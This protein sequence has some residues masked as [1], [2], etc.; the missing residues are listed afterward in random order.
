MHRI[1]SFAAATVLLCIAAAPEGVA[2][3]AG[4]TCHEFTV[5][6]NVDD[7]NGGPWLSGHTYVLKASVTVPSNTT[8]TIQ[9]GA[10][11][12]TG[13]SVQHGLNAWGTVKAIGTA[14]SPILFTS[15][16]DDTGGD[17]NG[18][19]GAT[20]PG[21]GD[22]PSVRLNAGSTNSEFDHCVV[23]FGGLGG[24]ASVD[25]D[26]DGLVL[27]NTTIEL[28]AG[29]GLRFNN[30]LVGAVED[31]VFDSCLRPISGVSVLSVATIKNCT[32][33]GNAQGDV[34]WADGTAAAAFSGNVTWEKAN[35]L[36][37]NGV[38]HLWAPITVPNGT[39]FRVKQ[40]VK[41]KFLTTLGYVNVFGT[42]I[43]EGTAGDP[44]VFT[45]ISDDAIGGDTAGDGPTTG[46][47]GSWRLV[48]LNFNSSGNVFTHTRFRFAGGQS[49]AAVTLANSDVT[50]T[51]CRFESSAKAGLSPLTYQPIVA[52]CQFNDNA[53]EAIDKVAIDALA[54]YSNNTASGNG[55][56]DAI[57]LGGGTL[58]TPLTLNAASAFNG[59]GAFMV[60]STIT[61]GAAGALTLAPGVILKFT[62]AGAKLS[63]SGAL[64]VDA[65]GSPVVL[66]SV[67]D[68]A[69][70]GDLNANGGAT[71]PAPGDWG[72]IEFTS[73]AVGL[74]KHA[75]IRYAGSGGSASVLISNV[76]PT[77]ESV[78]IEKGGGDGLGASGP[79]TPTFTNCAFDDNAGAPVA[80]VSLL[81]VAGFTGC[82]AQ[83]NGGGDVLRFGWTS[84]LAP[85][86]LKA[87]NALNGS[88]VFAFEGDILINGGGSL[89]I[90]PGVGLKF[91]GGYKI[92]AGGPLVVNG[93]SADPVI[94]TSI[95]DD[96]FGGDSG[97]DG[98]TS[99][100]PGDWW[101]IN[102]SNHAGSSLSYA[103]LRFSGYIDQPGI[104]LSNADP[105]LDHVTVGQGKGDGLSL[106]N[107]FPAVTSCAFDQCRRPVVGVRAAALAGFQGNT[108][109][110][111]LEGDAI[112]IA[113]AGTSPTSPTTIDQSMSLNGA[114]VFVVAES[115]QFGTNEFVTVGK[116]VVFRFDTGLQMSFN[117]TL[118]VNGTS[119][120]PVVFTS[121][122][123]D[124]Y[125]GD[126]TG[127]GN[128]PPAP[129]DWTGLR[130]AGNTDD[131]LVNYAIVRY[132]GAGGAAAIDLTFA[133]PTFC[134]L[135]IEHSAGDAIHANG[136]SAPTL[137]DV[138]ID[139]NGGE[140]VAGVTWGVLGKFD[141]V[142][143]SN[144]GG[145]DAT[146]VTSPY[147]GD[148]IVIDKED[149]FG[150]CIVV[151]VS[152]DP[153]NT[154]G[155]LSFTEGVVVKA[156]PGVRLIAK[157]IRGTGTEKVRFTSI[158]D[159]TIAGDTNGDGSASSPAPGDWHGVR[160]G[161][162]ASICEHALVRYAGE[163][164]PSFPQNE[165]LAISA[166]HALSV[167]AEH[168]S[169]DGVSCNTGDNVVAWKNQRDGIVGGLL[170]NSTAVGNA[171]FGF[172]A[173]E[174]LYCISWNNNDGSQG[175]NYIYSGDHVLAGKGCNTIYS[176]GS[177][178]SV[179]PG[180]GYMGN[181]GST[182]WGNLYADPKFVDEANGDLRLK[183]TSPALNY[184]L[185]PPPQ[186]IFQDNTICTP[187]G[188]QGYWYPSAPATTRDH[189]EF[190]RLIDDDLNGP[191]PLLADLGA[192]ERAVFEMVTGG[193]PR[194]GE[195]FTLTVLGPA[196]SAIHFVGVEGGGDALVGGVGYL[197]MN[198][199]F[200]IQLVTV[201]TN[202]ALPLPIPDDPSLSGLKVN[203]QAGGV[204]ANGASLSNVFRA[205]ILG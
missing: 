9:P 100:T 118:N 186:I 103:E 162:T 126:A 117:G 78:V 19:G 93:T 119:A 168:S 54:G 136:N 101:G 79:V 125:G 57:V 153:L 154:G 105:P 130:F 180:T 68:D 88:G 135:V 34:V 172:N 31:S 47:P 114:G 41:V 58:S 197:L 97:G 131:S 72:G 12:K 150:S 122:E 62:T 171:G 107:A 178:L 195:T 28:G 85:V 55:S 13:A 56:G 173:N 115:V 45:T 89:A 139:D 196:G 90:D 156:H 91:T 44:V 14:S 83:G 52:Q 27:K 202:F 170:T 21:P 86:V 4:P 106:F 111:N 176:I 127:N 74:V 36:N 177:A 26:A 16:H 82:T 166:W 148:D 84:V 138:T 8:L 63:V 64:T 143:A 11:I 116:G 24:V 39:L 110:G 30:S 121:I 142:S 159:D 20:G 35:T 51:G 174:A 42:M 137:K 2:Q 189:R 17:H 87:S 167:R 147:V 193:E 204:T 46:T 183:S 6:T 53:T 67:H 95:H 190:P 124:A 23:R 61:V 60:A 205:R 120:E 152:P 129:G 198:P 145:G 163:L 149:Y 92:D 5:P 48:Q 77:F 43:T 165:E 201:P 49:P 182:G 10:I 76:G 94:F 146:I 38:V 98:A 25:V 40:G 112:R 15:L 32:A 123:D 184:V 181:C 104:K 70:G 81:A 1:R 37:A 29:D 141:G 3:C 65:S 158:K 200:V 169:G 80:G 151:T 73:T 59:T 66:T 188:Q 33:S 203:F 71:T 164:F 140:A 96:T 75:R 134:N 187:W 157:E 99:G 69:Y 50:F 194:V 109:T 102:I 175:A 7:T 113:G 192:H 133:D 132:A 185:I 18:D 108:G 160:T 179:G 128:V 161:G 22:W 199:S 191:H 155:S 144:N